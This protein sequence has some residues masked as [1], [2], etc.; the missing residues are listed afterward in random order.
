MGHHEMNRSGPELTREDVG[1]KRTEQVRRL[2]NTDVI[3]VRSGDGT[4]SQLHHPFAVTP[5]MTVV[6]AGTAMADAVP[7]TVELLRLCTYGSVMDLA[8]EAADLPE[9]FQAM[10]EAA[11][12]YQDKIITLWHRLGRL[13]FRENM[14]AYD[15]MMG[16]SM[17]SVVP[18]LT[19]LLHVPLTPATFTAYISGY[20]LSKHGRLKPHG[21]FT[22]RK[23]GTPLKQL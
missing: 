11:L 22:T 21:I 5:E 7:W 20:F 16:L 2:V 18:M 19:E 15:G 9:D 1:D 6:Q 10:T 13:A 17:L 23:P 3:L 12:A 4:V 14:P 8:P